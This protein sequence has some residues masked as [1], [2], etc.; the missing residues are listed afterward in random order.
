MCF[1]LIDPKTMKKEVSNPANQFVHIKMTVISVDANIS[2]FNYSGQMVK[3]Q[4]TNQNKERIQLDG[5]NA[6]I[7]F[8]KVE[9][10]GEKPM[11]QK[12]MVNP[13]GL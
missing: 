8:I 2:V 9:R 1:T 10:N 12:L 4:K 11:V 13:S 5:L 3:S 7:Y 6:G